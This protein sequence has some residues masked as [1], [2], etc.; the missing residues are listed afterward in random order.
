MRRAGLAAVSAAA[1]L[2]AVLA[3][4]AEA[5]CTSAPSL[6]FR[7][8]EPLYAAAG[9]IQ[10]YRLSLSNSGLDTS[11]NLVITTGDVSFAGRTYVAPSFS[12]TLWGV[13]TLLDAAWATDLAGPWT[14]GEPSDGA[15]EP[16]YLRWVV[17]E[18]RPGESGALSWRTLTLAGAEMVMETSVSATLSCDSLLTDESELGYTATAT[19]KRIISPLAWFRLHDDPWGGAD[20]ASGVAADGAGNAFVVGWESRAD[21][22]QGDDWLVRKYS[23]GGDLLWSTAYNSAENLGDEALGVAVDGS[24]NAIVVGY[25]RADVGLENWLVRKYDGAGNLVWSRTYADPDPAGYTRAYC[26]AADGSG[27]IV[28]AGYEKRADLSEEDNW[29]VTKYDSGGSLL[30]SRTYNDPGNG[31]DYPRGAAFDPAGNV[32]VGGIED[33]AD[34]GESLN[35]IVR[36]YDPWGVLLWSR[37]YNSPGNFVDEIWGVAVDSGGNVVAGGYE[38]RND[39]GQSSNWR[40]IKWDGGGDEMWSATYDSPANAGDGAV[41]VAVDGSG[42]VIAAGVEARPDL[43]QDANWLVRKYDPAGNLVDSQS[44]DGLIS[45]F[46]VAYAVTQLPGTSAV[47][48]AGAEDVR[49]EGQDFAAARFALAVFVPPT[50]PLGLTA[51]GYI[52]YIGLE[53]S[54]SSPGSRAIQGYRIFR[55]TFAGV[56][57]TAATLLTSVGGAATSIWVDA[58][59]VPGTTYYYRVAAFDVLGAEGLLSMEA[60]AK[61]IVL[62][63][64]NPEIT[65]KYRNPDPIYVNGGEAQL[66]RLS[67]SNSGSSTGYNI[68]IT[69]Q[70][71]SF[72]GRTYTAPSLSFTLTGASTVT[73]TAWATDIAGPWTPGEPPDGTGEPLY[74]R[75]VVSEL[76]L[77]TS[78]ILSYQMSTLAGAELVMESYASATLSCDSWFLSNFALP[79]SVTTTGKRIEPPLTWIKL[80]DSP[81]SSDEEGKGVAI[82]LAGFFYAGGFEQRADFLE[83]KNWLVGRY[84]S[85][86]TVFWTRTMNG[87]GNG[88]DIAN[89]VSANMD[90]AI[91][92]V[93]VVG[94]EW[95]GDVGEG[96]NAVIRRYGNVPGNVV[97]T[98]TYNSLGN[99]DDV[100]Y[101]VARDDGPLTELAVGSEQRPDLIQGK[102]W[103]ID[104]YDDS[105]NRIWSKTYNS[106]ANADDEAKA[107]AWDWLE[108]KSL[109]AVAGYETR[110]DLAQAENWLVIKLDDFGNIAWSRTYNSPANGNDVAQSVVF[111]RNGNVI[112]AGYE[113]RMDLG[114]GY[115]WRIIK[116]SSVGDVLW[117]IDY[118]G[119]SGGDDRANGVS[120]DLVGNIYVCGYETVVGQGRNW[121]V[122]KYDNAGNFISSATHDGLVSGDDVLNGITP[123]Y[124]GSTQDVIAVG[125]EQ[126]RDEGEDFSV[127]RYDLGI[128]NPPNA[129]SGLTADGYTNYVGLQWTPSVGGT[130]A[131]QGYKIFRQTFAGVTE[132]SYLTSVVGAATSTFVD[133]TA[134]PYTRY[135]YRVLAFDVLGAES[136]LSMEASAVALGSPVLVV[137]KEV[138]PAV[139]VC[140]GGV[141][142]YTVSWSNA[143]GGTAYGLTLTDTLPNGTTYANPG[144]VFFAQADDTGTPVVDPYYATAAA[145]PWTAGEPVDGA[146]PSLLLRWTVDR[147]APG[148]SGFVLFQATVSATLTGG[149]LI[150]NRSSATVADDPVTYLTEGTSNAVL[151]SG[152]LSVA[153]ASPPKATLGQWFNVAVTVTNTGGLTVNGLSATLFVGPGFPFVDVIDG[154]LPPGPMSLAAATATTF[155][156]TWSASGLGLAQ[157]TATAEGTACG[158]TAITGLGGMSTTVVTPASLAASLSALS[159]SVCLGS[160]FLVTLTVSNSGGADASGVATLAPRVAG[161]GSAVAAA[162]PYPPM[163]AVVPG[164][165]NM[166][167][168]WT[169]TGSAPG[170]IDLSAT[171]TGADA[172]AGWP[173]SAGLAVS[174]TLTVLDAGVL[175]ATVVIY[176]EVVSA[177][178]WVTAALTVTNTG[179]ANVDGILPTAQVGPGAG[180]VLLKTGPEPPGPLSL[181]PASATTFVW[182]WSTSGAGTPVFSLTAEGSTCGGLRLGWGA[183]P[184]TI[185]APAALVASLYAFPSPRNIGQDFLVTLTVTNAGTA[186]A[187]GV[188]AAWFTIAGTGGATKADGPLPSFPVTIPGGTSLT[189]TWTYTGSVAG[190]IA[191]TA[192]ATG[193]DHN[194]GLT[195]TSGPVTSNPEVIT[196]P[197]ALAARLSILSGTVCS[198]SAVMVTLTVTNTGGG[199]ANAVTASPLF[200]TGPGSLAP[201]AGPSPPMP[202]T[203]AGGNWRVFTWTMTGATPGALGLSI[204]VTGTDANSG[205]P[206]SLGPVVSGGATVLVSGA[207][208]ALS[209]SWPSSTMLGGV[210]TVTLTVTNT[211]GADV[212][213]VMPSISALPG[214]RVTAVVPPVP[215]GP[216]TLTPGAMQTFEW[217]FTSTGGGRVD[218]TASAGGYACAG[219]TAVSSTVSSLITT[220]VGLSAVIS[221]GPPVVGLADLVTVT[222]KVD[223]TGLLTALDVVPDLVLGGTG[224]AVLVSGPAPSTTGWLAPGTSVTFTWVYEATGGGTL[225]FRGTATPANGGATAALPAPP[226]EVRETEDSLDRMVVYPNPC[227]RDRALGGSV[228][229]RR[230]PAFTKVT[231]FNVAGDRIKAL[232]ADGK[233][234]AVWDCRNGE[235]TRVAPGVYLFL[236]KSPSGARKHGKIQVVK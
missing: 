44:H 186:A 80:Y 13:G 217:T 36:K 203:L 31:S 83:G 39:L 7:N 206:L 29:V 216:V 195:L 156:W 95:R 179:G 65:L 59:I 11:Y 222:M 129:P 6:S 53:W 25:E 155:V 174:S 202:V 224:K 74:L 187:D 194:S 181:G 117:S 215:P 137:H 221:A 21:I 205:L 212:G 109:F 106:P 52:G 124:S 226:V 111:D 154:P 193:T 160:G 172:N 147:V 120:V 5:A 152:S 89:G 218:F 121:V 166:T 27:N 168:T 62:E 40:I 51:T 92:R 150:L 72:N 2:W 71:N 32:F 20:S 28:V 209:T 180:L 69:T 1:A 8:P 105:G 171:V 189:F 210:I 236:A 12:S 49:G 55:Q 127:V 132:G 113:E 43:G 192:T 23:P 19:G 134:V 208:S 66:Y 233:G 91:F 76:R 70:A 223:S 56:T 234:L 164:G 141:L 100:Y 125:G 50:A 63:P 126:V 58:A 198:G 148:K 161:S 175:S 145:G 153:V 33:R 162:G 68:V 131:I 163:P 130:R 144:S 94:S 225:E 112:V 46:D 207:L 199:D 84:N 138:S 178:Q 79:F 183:V 101:G 114:Q 182:T 184:L 9:E 107:V 60:F 220:S 86:G 170:D 213:N 108:M 158:A 133:A 227:D 15:G 90:S 136:L 110:T 85:S 30:W 135:F 64:C 96:A 103:L 159:A 14:S 81:A 190:T 54:P 104:Y 88:D 139:G 177:G 99:A 196:A 61:S 77:G 22:G 24:G 197:A 116:Y 47:V 87:F 75:W 4:P 10:F 204:T 97:W 67:F 146:G 229:F 231:I 165:T 128:F 200:V 219:Y 169:F 232:E 93:F 173:L 122:R 167:F 185:V 73:G 45:G 214:G 201:L 143:G 98:R 3:A 157:F 35:W 102:N 57:S 48:V 37:T 115:N 17:S 142:T 230:M 38:Q 119:P 191:F 18:L 41:G 188:D 176:P 42:N 211:G 16:L 34:I 123:D 228:K 118:N 26:V 149:S 82:D 78:G 140:A 235:G 151:S